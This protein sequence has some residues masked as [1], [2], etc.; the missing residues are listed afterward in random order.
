MLIEPLEPLRVRLP[1]GECSLEVGKT[2]DLPSIQAEKLLTMAH[3]RVRVVTDPSPETLAFNL[4]ANQS[5]HAHSLNDE[6]AIPSGARIRF[7]SP[8]FG[9]LDAIVIEARGA[10][11]WVWHPM[12]ECEA[13]LPRHW[14][15]EIIVSESL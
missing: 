3:G 7:R 6:E 5:P 10:V 2:Y 1:E 13:C 15:E 4:N 12:R 9:S 8:L 14:V 11:V